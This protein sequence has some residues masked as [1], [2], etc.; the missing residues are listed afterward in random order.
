MYIEFLKE[1][2]ENTQESDKYLL[3]ILVVYGFMECKVLE[4]PIG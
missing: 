4:K 3:K 1:N 2:G